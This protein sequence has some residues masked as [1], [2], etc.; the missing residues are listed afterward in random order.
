MKVVA[1]NGSARKQG[2]TALLLR[3]VLAPLGRK[4]G[5]ETELIELAGNELRECMSCYVCYL[6]KS[7][8]ASLKDI[9]NDCLRKKG[10]AEVILPDSPTNDFVHGQPLP[11]TMH[12]FTGTKKITPK[13]GTETIQPAPRF[14]S[15]RPSCY[16]WLCEKCLLGRK[17]GAGERLQKINQ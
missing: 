1:F 16:N 12:S 15:S 3:E 6:E 2:N 7:V 14:Y 4:T 8:P 13:A 10:T 9:V 5:A 11:K 17:W